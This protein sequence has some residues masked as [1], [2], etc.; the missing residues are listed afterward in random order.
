MKETNS[1]TSTLKEMPSLAPQQE[2]QA[3]KKMFEIQE[4]LKKELE[5]KETKLKEAQAKLEELKEKQKQEK[6]EK[7]KKLNEIE[8][9][10]KKK[11]IEIRKAIIA[12]KKKLNN[13]ANDLK[14]KGP[15]QQKINAIVPEIRADK[16]STI[17][18]EELIGEVNKQ[19]THDQKIASYSAQIESI[20][21]KQ[22]QLDTNLEELRKKEK[23]IKV[24]EKEFIFYEDKNKQDIRR[25]QAFEKKKI[26]L[27]LK[28][29]EL[30]K[31]KTYRDIAASNV[32]IKKE[33]L[34]RDYGASSKKEYEAK[35][36][37]IERRIKNAEKYQ[38]DRAKI[39][40]ELAK[41]EGSDGAKY[42]EARRERLKKEMQLNLE[43]IERKERELLIGITKA[44]KQEGV[45]EGQSV[46]DRLKAENVFLLANK[47]NIE[48]GISGLKQLEANLQKENK[49]FAR[50]QNNLAND[51]Q[52]SLNKQNKRE[53]KTTKVEGKKIE[54]LATK[55]ESL[56]QTK[57]KLEQRLEA[58]KKRADNKWNPFRK[59]DEMR[60]ERV[61]NAVD[62][63]EKSLN[64]VEAKIEGKGK[65]IETHKA[66]TQHYE[67]T[68]TKTYDK[69]KTEAE[70]QGFKKALLKDGKLSSDLKKEIHEN[71]EVTSLEKASNFGSR[72]VERIKEGLSKGASTAMSVASYVS[73][74]IKTKG[75]EGQSH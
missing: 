45:Q 64:K 47:E 72:N 17:M 61:Q 71:V 74:A 12:N 18:K 67:T 26:E 9:A 58:L 19:V 36:N 8:I 15:A 68:K 3:K 73:S 4:E 6:D 70:N 32:Q 43:T 29:V 7:K 28:S 40:D 14:E 60:A 11:I 23:T 30:E 16:N 33:E 57:D 62:N 22:A 56:E 24:P 5:E 31:R 1:S 46:K 44:G 25:T 52:T 39:A 35:Q 65:I 27:E 13:F 21:K 54:K 75:K 49:E 50:A 10:G 66:R 48:Q 55:K 42:S 41:L 37:E 53:Q 38:K 63:R 20:K 51:I 34:L 59:I 2:E 69:I